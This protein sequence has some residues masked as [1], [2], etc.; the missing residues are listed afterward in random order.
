MGTGGA[1]LA[2]A[3]GQVVPSAVSHI[4]D[5][6]SHTPLLNIDGGCL[7]LPQS[8]PVRGRRWMQM[9]QSQWGSAQGGLE[10]GAGHQEDRDRCLQ[11]PGEFLVM[12]SKAQAIR[13]K[14][15]SWTPSNL[16]LFFHKGHS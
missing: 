4:P 14:Y 15:I 5:K 1:S 10:G 7:V 9:P 16:Q 8:L 6:V 2:V 12:T 3:K 11:R 13:G